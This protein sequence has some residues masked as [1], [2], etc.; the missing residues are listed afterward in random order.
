MICSFGLPFALV[1]IIYGGNIFLVTLFYVISKAFYF[2]L[3]SDVFICF[4]E[5][6]VLSLFYFLKFSKLKDKQ[7][8][9]L[10]ISALISTALEFYYVLILRKNLA[11]FSLKVLLLLFAANYF[12]KLFKIIRQKFLFFKFSNLDY[13]YFALICFLISLGLFQFDLRLFK[14]DIFFLMTAM[15]FGCKVLPS[16]KFFVFALSLGLGGLIGSGQVYLLTF[17]SLFSL[18]MINFKSKNKHIYLVGSIISVGIL[19]VIEPSLDLISVLVSLIAIL[20]YLIF[21]KGLVNRF[22]ILFEINSL[23][24]MQE[25]LRREKIYEIKNKLALMSTTLKNMQK[26]FKFLMVGK[27]SREKASTELA[28]DVIESCCKHCENYMTCFSQN[29]NKKSMFEE[30][31]L[32][33]LENRSINRDD[34]V[35]GLRAYCYKDMIILSEINQIAES[36]LKYERTMKTEDLSKLLIADELG[37]F[38]DIFSNFSKMVQIKTRVN[39]DKSRALKESLINNLIDVKE[40][41]ISENQEGIEKIDLIAINEH[42]LKRDM[43]ENISKIARTK[44]K[45]LQANHLNF[46]GL[47]LATFVPCEKLKLSVAV[48]SKAKDKKCGDNVTMTKLS[49]NKYFIALADGMGH[50]EAAG[51]MSAMVLSLIRSMYQIGFDDELIIESIN[52]LV[53]PAGLDNF[54][55]LDACVVDLNKEVCTFIKLGASVSVLKR[56]TSSEMIAC[57]SLPIGIV[58][59]IK[60]TITKKHLSVGDTIFLASDGI[61]DSFPNI[62]NYKN[63]I[64]DSKIINL[65]KYLDDVVFDCNYQNKKHPDDMTII[66]INL[67]KN[68]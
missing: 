50:G 47:S 56:K 55:S 64:N 65:Q 38:A 62:E 17:S 25:N 14:L 53:V 18:I 30:L 54:S 24:L 43:V 49:N 46:S 68:Y 7:L 41:V 59:K 28:N 6:V 26:D 51:R 63:Y 33:A 8:F 12:Y 16:E 66:A 42:I 36:F 32:K 67:L 1:R 37:N 34:I 21:P 5:V 29:I 52:K 27:I 4:F 15:L 58:E 10:N 45:L 19:F 3:F 2:S 60:P 48:S 20:L 39:Q 35:M 40:V 9:L 11:L 44:F 57:S 31:I 22:E 13:I 61:V 23:N